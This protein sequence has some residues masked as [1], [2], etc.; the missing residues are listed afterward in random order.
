MLG[1]ELWDPTDVRE[2]SVSEVAYFFRRMG[3]KKFGYVDAI[4][5]YSVDGKLLLTFEWEVSKA[6]TGG[7]KYLI[8]TSTH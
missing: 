8:Y 2:W 7:A 5:K 3:F 1:K 6:T 4:R